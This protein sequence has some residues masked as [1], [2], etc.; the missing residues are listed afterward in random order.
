MNHMHSFMV[1]FLLTFSSFV[2]QAQLFNGTIKDN[3]TGNALQGVS[4]LLVEDNQT[5]LSDINGVFS[6][7][8]ADTNVKTIRFELDGYMFEEQFKVSPSASLEITLRKAIKSAASI[9]EEGYVANGCDPDVPNDAE[10]NVNFVQSDLKGD[11]APDINYTRRDPSAVISANGKYYV[12][13]SYS[14][15][16][17]E[18]K[19]APWDLNDIY[20]ST[21]ADGESWTEHG[22]AVTRGEAGAFDH[23]S[24]FTTEIFV[25]E[26]KYYLVYQA[27]AD[28]AGVL[29][30]NFV[31]MSY[32]DSPD[33]PWTKVAEPVLRPTYTDKLFFDN[34]AVHDPCI[35]F[36]QN[37]FSLYYKGECSCFDNSGCQR[38][39]NPV[40][41][42]GKQ[43]KWGVAI[44]DNPTG[45]YV[46]S[47]HNPITNTGHEVMVW[48]YNDGVAILQHQDGPEAQTI[49]FSQDGLN[50]EIQGSATNLPE[51]AGLYRPENPGNDPH[52]GIQWGLCHVLRWDGGTPKG[53]M[54]LKKFE[55]KK[56]NATGMFLQADTI[57]MNI[58]QTRTLDPVFKPLESTSNLTVT[59]SN[60][61][62]V[63]VIADGALEALTL[64]FSKITA[65]TVSGGYSDIIVVK[66]TDKQIEKKTMTVQAEQFTSTGNLDGENYGGPD[67]MGKTGTGV[68][69]VNKNDW[70]KYNVTVPFDG[71]YYVDY[72]VSTP[73]DNAE[74]Q[75]KLGERMLNTENV[76][77]SGGWSS[78][79]TLP[80][81]GTFFLKKGATEITIFASGTNDWQWNM[82]KFTLYSERESVAAAKVILESLSL[83]YDS[84]KLV[85]DSVV[86]VSVQFTPEDAED[87]NLTWSSSDAAVASVANG[88]ITAVSAG[89][90]VI[91]VS[92]V[93]TTIKTTMI[94]IVE[95]KEVIIDPLDPLALARE[96]PAIYPNPVTDR[97]FLPQ[98]ISSFQLFDTT[99]K[100]I[101]ASVNNG[102]NHT[103]AD[104]SIL[105]K[106]IYFVRF[107]LKGEP[108]TYRVLKN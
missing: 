58:G 16:Y 53:W 30:R 27:A 104:V 63:K 73:S 68:N 38:W 78:F 4:V 32:A 43:V 34:N 85:I 76:T 84:A 70:A 13:Y 67:G 93:N 9:R 42:L 98:G 92:D 59:S 18:G 106:G 81:S 97:L 41:G 15:S 29:N 83:S 49:Q 6:V 102:V 101:K 91:T 46:K 74:V 79:Y 20:Y 100:A 45:P 88:I 90:A 80:G 75:L 11:L 25:H 69:F 66:V 2:V 96:R 3:Q 107:N 61:S 26:G 65:A 50:F 36:Y 33:G 57:Y 108:Y 23:R 39:C 64:G 1:C 71:S 72:L 14:N 48:K 82:D 22:A 44:A 77:N 52:A 17:G 19:T 8:A 5:T 37:K 56:V 54:H 62:V 89:I 12:W 86:T 87:V 95:E 7:T 55:I 21:S 31:G 60:E 10:W 103:Q 24:V 105:N 99:G 35:I 28:E 51:A 40:C 94:V 47:D